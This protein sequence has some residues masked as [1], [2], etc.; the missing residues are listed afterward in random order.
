MSLFKKLFGGGSAPKPTAKSETYKDFKITP[1]PAKE[2][3]GYR[4]SAM[5]EKDIGGEVKTHHVIRADTYGDE[6]TATDASIFKAR[7]VIDEQGD[8]LFG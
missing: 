7:Q 2:T 1:T 3:G 8:R 5:I 6:Q 4:I